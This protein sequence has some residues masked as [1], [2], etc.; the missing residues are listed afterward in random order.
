MVRVL[1]G[2][3]TVGLALTPSRRPRAAPA[4]HAARRSPSVAHTV[5]DAHG[6]AGRA[7]RSAATP[8]TSRWST[9]TPTPPIG[10]DADRRRPRIGSVQD[11]AIGGNLNNLTLVSRN[12]NA[13]I[14]IERHADTRIGAIDGARG[15]RQPQQPDGL[16]NRNTNAAI[17]VNCIGR[18]RH[19]HDQR[20]QG[21][22]R[23]STTSDPGQ[24]Q[25]QRRDR[26]RRHRLLRHRQHRQVRRLRLALPRSLRLPHSALVNSAG[27]SPSAPA[28]FARF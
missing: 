24:P 27:R 15:R 26:R 14:G 5:R 25:H 16:V 6:P 1:H 12:T 22:R 18:H 11:S 19:R 4:R 28:A 8:T 10:K 3:L 17:G 20:C 21:R 9:A 13:A 23:S 7:S 2:R